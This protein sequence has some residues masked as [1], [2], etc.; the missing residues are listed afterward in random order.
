MI[1]LE[2]YDTILARL[3][4]RMVSALEFIEAAESA[5]WKSRTIGLFLTEP[6]Y[7][8]KVKVGDEALVLK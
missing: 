6:L 4:V 7:H 8:G 1:S 5:G 3:P 2:P